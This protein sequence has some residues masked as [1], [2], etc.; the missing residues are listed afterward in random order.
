MLENKLRPVTETDREELL[1]IS[2][3]KLDLFANCQRRYKKRYVDCKY[4]SS[5]TLPLELGSILHKGLEIK[6]N[7]LIQGKEVDYDV[8]HK[9]VMDGCDEVTE[10]SSEHINGVNDIKK[11]YSQ[12]WLESFED[13]ENKSY[14]EKIK[15]YLDEVLPTR[16]EEEGWIVVGTEVPFEFVYDDRC[17]V[18]GF[19]DRVDKN[20]DGELRI[21][22]YKSSKKVF[23]DTKIKS[24]LQMVFYDLAAIHLWNITP[25]YHEYDFILL[26]EKQTS[27]KDGVCSK[28]YLTRG[29]K[30][31]DK[32][33]DQLNEAYKDKDFP[34]SPTPLCWWCPYTTSASLNAD[35][36][37]QNDC[38][39]FSLWTPENKVFKVNKEWNPGEE[40][41][42]LRKLVF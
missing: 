22:D 17:I 7:Y 6:G 5:E 11:K 16:M 42:P 36:T 39:Y 13:Q 26:N 12:V 3:S 35:K 28:G 21:V 31:I 4:T 37:Y 8:I 40:D 32:L 14:D 25:K 27:E 2:Y 19:I 15:I 29:I 24:P 34:P 10:K 9:T 18:H 41:K 33:L 30:K 23:P 38:Q 20:A 1:T